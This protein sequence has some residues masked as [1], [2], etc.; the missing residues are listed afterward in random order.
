[1]LSTERWDNCEKV[2]LLFQFTALTCDENR[3]FS[4]IVSNL[5]AQSVDK[6]DAG[7]SFIS[8][9]IFYVMCVTFLPV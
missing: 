8:K 6:I 1:M 9:R 2:P 5:L 4:Q 3:I 7:R